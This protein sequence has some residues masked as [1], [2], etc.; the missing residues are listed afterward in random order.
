MNNLS[1]AIA[2]VCWPISLFSGQFLTVLLLS[3]SYCMREMLKKVPE[4]DWLCEEC[5]FAEESESQ[6]QGEA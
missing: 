1:S 2:C 6:K 3:I 4:G 5:K